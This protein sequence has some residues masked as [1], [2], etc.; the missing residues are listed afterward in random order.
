MNK[1]RTALAT[2]TALAA[3]G[4][5][6]AVSAQS[7]VVIYG[8]VDV[9]YVR[10]G[11]GAAGSSGKVTSGVES[12]SRLGFKGV[13]DLGG[14]LSAVFVLENGF[15]ADTGIMGQ[16]GLLFGR[17]VYV[18]LAGAAGTLTLG[19]QYT[20]EF[21]ALAT[22]DPFSVGMAGDAKNLMS[23]SGAS[24]SRMDNS[25]K[26]ATPALRGFSAELVYGAGEVA[27]S[28][29]AGR[30]YGG[31]AGYSA[32]PLAL[33]AGYHRRNNDTA[34][35][36]NTDDARNLL[37]TASYDFGTVKAHVAWGSG[38]G[39]NSSALR[40]TNNPYGRTP[41]PQAST[42]ST[43]TLLGASVPFGVQTLLL[44]WVRKNDKTVRKQ[45]ASQWGIGYRYA[46]SRRTDLYASAARIRNRNGA[47]YTVGSSIEAGTGNRAWNLGVRHTF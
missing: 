34:A 43:E 29:E 14:G 11:G 6:G 2:L 47:G 33:R 1:T 45:D 42:D 19:R 28:G 30:Q 3:I 27:G 31:A 32:G 5:C 4:A 37:L 17:Q 41:A 24:V 40:A 44:S 39:L 23:T 38:K 25:V 21:M 7:A 15:Q 36:R 35:V 10:E 20:P 46:L 8:L 13:E 26:Y 12:P 16:G 22:I 18:G 9:A